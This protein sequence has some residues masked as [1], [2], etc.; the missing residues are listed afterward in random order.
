MKEGLIYEGS[1]HVHFLNN[2][3]VISWPVH[4]EVHTA[5][6]LLATIWIKLKSCRL[7]SFCFSKIDMENKSLTWMA[8]QLHKKWI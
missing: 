6:T 3:I 1:I 5:F 7:A 2:K 4:H 8:M